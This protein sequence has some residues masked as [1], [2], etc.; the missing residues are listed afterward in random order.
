M[1]MARK[2]RR[3][4]ASGSGATGGARHRPAVTKV[5]AWVSAVLVL[6]VVAGGL[7]GYVKYREIWDGIH[8]DVVSGLGNR[9]PKYNDALNILVFGSDSR[10][11]LTRQQQLTLHVGADGCGCS[12]TI[13]VVHLSPG[14]HRAVVLNIPRD[15]MVPVF[16]CAAGPG[17]AG[18][19]ANP[20]GV[21][22]INQTLSRGGP[23]CL[24]K[25]VEQT[26]GIHI[27]HFIQLEFTG[28]VKVVDDVGGVNVC[29][30]QNI[31]DANSGLHITAGEHHINGLTFLEFWRAR[32]SIADG[33][34]LKRINRDDL[35]LAEMFRGI[36]SSGLLSSPTRLL[37]V[38]DDAA[39]A[40]Y[41]TDAGLTQTD[42]LQIAQSFRGLSSNNVQFI[43]AVTQPYPPAPAQV[44]LVQPGDTQLFSAIA[45]D[46]ALPKKSRAPARTAGPTV[47]P[48]EVRVTVM[49]GTT[50]P[51]LAAD[52]ATTLAA[53]GFQLVGTGNVAASPG[54]V[55]EYPSAAEL[56]AARTLAAQVSGATLRQD[57]AVSA[58]TVELILGAG[59]SSLA[60]QASPAGT[61]PAGPPAPGTQ[62][63]ASPSASP[64]LGSLAKTYGGINANANCQTDSGAFAP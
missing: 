58:G 64:S 50:V 60:P 31:S 40:I 7:F 22:Q 61:T 1:R 39:K 57:P 16:A 59:F 11:G 25:T 56:P 52:T 34:D 41:A 29:V 24:Y 5:A 38:V 35:L 13:M 28:V 46:V 32:Y 45:H 4:S 53:R 20:D 36:I 49:N 26:T 42:I 54:S 51:R 10:A 48:A 21:V 23:S 44:E 19:A 14:R 18:Q 30:P 3:H 43:E 63:S 55:I 27:D 6:V 2:G 9:P 47:A 8:H 62:P 33:T 37:P 17:Y 15:T 12:D